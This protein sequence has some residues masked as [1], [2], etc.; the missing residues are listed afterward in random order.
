VLQ[1][2]S[3]VDYANS[4]NRVFEVG[5]ELVFKFGSSNTIEIK[6]TRAAPS[7]RC[8]SADDFEPT[9][10]ILTVLLDVNGNYEISQSELV[11]NENGA[12]FNDTHQSVIVKLLNNDHTL[13]ADASYDIT[14][15]KFKLTPNSTWN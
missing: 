8:V 1:T 11:S 7:T 12:K 9:A 2:T 14:T 3:S 15:N 5:S 4:K 10:G 6:D 13:F